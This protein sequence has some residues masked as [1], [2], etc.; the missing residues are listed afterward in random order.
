MS[1]DDRG[2]SAR[3]E[4]EDKEAALEFHRRSHGK[5]EIRSKV[6]LRGARDLA[7]AYT[8]GVAEPC[9]EIH[10]EMLRVYEYT[11]KGNQVAIVTDGSAV[12][13]LG[14]IGPRA[15]LPVMEG[16][17]ILFKKFAGID[18][19]PICLDTQDT[20]EIVTAVKVLQPT[21]GGINLE[22]ISAPR[23]FEVE[24]RLR[25]EMTI[26]VFHDD[27]HGTAIITL[28]ALRNG[29]LLTDRALD[30]TKIVING[31]GAAGIAIAKL[32]V[33]EG[34]QEV[35]ICDSKGIIHQGR[36]EGMNPYK[37]EIAKITNRAKRE[38]NLA[39]AM[40]G[41]D[42]FIGVSVGNTVTKQMVASMADDPLIFAQANPI[43]EIMP[44]E[45]MKAGAR[46]IATGRSDYPNQINNVMGFP[47][48]FRG[49]LDVMATDITTEM[50][51]AAA[52]ALAELVTPDELRPELLIPSPMDPRVVPAVAMAVGQA[53]MDVG[54]A[55][56]EM[57]RARII[58]NV[59]FGK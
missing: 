16:K 31:A 27:Q 23:C 22:D 44:E 9:R 19:I 30:D 5:I 14:N 18:G 47:G 56:R 1:D 38:G 32:L 52:K 36:E 33:H 21:F 29:I 40:E 20:D 35:I 24:R 12:L 43:P 15:A 34:A 4:T 10:K 53:A 48:V 42:A 6:P 58:E 13:G 26:P 41:A 57:D 59:T 45:A 46:V 17:A 8:P 11:N 2:V 37:H 49:C 54:V 7:L 55:R 51:V 3:N 50:E 25:E 28:A 39:H